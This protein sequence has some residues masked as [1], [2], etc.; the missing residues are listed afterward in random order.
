ML[1]EGTLSAP[2]ETSLRAST[3]GS[4]PCEPEAITTGGWRSWASRSLVRGAGGQVN[5]KIERRSTC[6]SALRPLGS[7]HA[8]WLFHLLEVAVLNRKD[9]QYERSMVD[10]SNWQLA[11]QNLCSRPRHGSIPVSHTPFTVS[12]SSEISGMHLPGQPVA[13]TST[14]L[15]ATQLQSHAKWR[16]TP[17]PT[18]AHPTAAA[19]LR[20]VL[21][22]R[23][24]TV[25]LAKLQPKRPIPPAIH[26]CRS[27]SYCSFRR[28]SLGLPAHP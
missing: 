11:H 25:T 5:A 18:E 16:G 24:T 28:H 26:R 19:F 9:G 8:Q 14:V 12:H 10:C 17:K 2:G 15:A 27:S 13:P 21:V 6:Q 3:F 22:C 7:R 23:R 1:G 4:R 20:V